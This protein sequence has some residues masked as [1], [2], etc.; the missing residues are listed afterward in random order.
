MNNTVKTLIGLCQGIEKGLMV[1][2]ILKN[3]LPRT[4]TIHDVIKGIFVFNPCGL[5]MKRV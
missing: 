2:L 5:G 4:T 1:T 3:R